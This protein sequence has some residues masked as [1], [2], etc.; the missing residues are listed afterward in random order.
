MVY[1]SSVGGITV[2][3]PIVRSLTARCTRRRVVI[4]DVSAFSPLFRGIPSGI[5]FHKT[6]FEKRRT[7][8]VNLK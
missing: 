8:L 6:S 7:K 1:F 3:V 5:V 2:T 4:L